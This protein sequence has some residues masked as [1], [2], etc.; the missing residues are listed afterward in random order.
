M[1]NVW[2][3]SDTHFGSQRHLTWCIRP[4][5]SVA[6][7]DHVMMCNW[8]NNVGDNDIVYHLGDFGNHKVLPYLKGEICIVKGNYDIGS[9]GQI[10]NELKPYEYLQ[11]SVEY[12]GETMLVCHDPMD[13]VH[14][15]Q[16]FLFGHIHKSQMIKKHGLN[17]G[18]DLHDFTPI[19]FER[20]M[21]YKRYIYNATDE[22]VFCGN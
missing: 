15:N 19:S 5:N 22:S 12:K 7:M 4:F 11:Y 10:H 13:V 18:V 9:D 8:N 21:Y 17:V 14:Y 1:R 3:T 2:F 16:F 6:E 20:V